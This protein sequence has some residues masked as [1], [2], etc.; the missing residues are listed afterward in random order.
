MSR[1][2]EALSDEVIAIHDKQKD[3][4]DAVWRELVAAIAARVPAGGLVVD[5][6]AG[7]GVVA[8][9]L[10]AAGLRVS[11]FDFNN[12]MLRALTRRA[13]G[14]VPV[15]CADITSLPVRSE[16]VDAVL[17]TN[18]LH[19]VREWRVAIAE[20]ARLLRP[21]GVLFVGLGNTGRSVV[22]GEIS[23][24][25]RSIVG[26]AGA[27][28]DVGVQAGEDFEAALHVAG[29]VVE[30]AVVVG[31]TVTRTVR[32]A[33]ERLQHNVFTWAPDVRQEEFDAAA[34]ATAEWATE[35]Y[36]YTDAEYEVEAELALH[37]A[38]KKVER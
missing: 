33:I 4:S 25:F 29:F 14:A 6:G 10:A 5:A 12:S 31:E 32:D 37:V 16:V 2:R 3:F 17:I 20:S 8:S 19:L 28:S 9:R 21:G 36:G 34:A 15:A 24:H 13:G 22:A 26:G 23:A 7:S 18:V 27:S 38:R 30:E 1:Y 11:G 35:R